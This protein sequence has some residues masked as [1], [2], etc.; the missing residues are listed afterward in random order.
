MTFTP[1]EVDYNPLRLQA[2]P[3]AIPIQ[4]P[5]SINNIVKFSVKPPRI[6]SHTRGDKA[7]NPWWRTALLVHT[8]DL[9][10]IPNMSDTLPKHTNGYLQLALQQAMTT[11]VALL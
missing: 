1:T 8:L 6:R 11:A 5:R 9:L 10:P 3:Y 7:W 2:Q 4:D